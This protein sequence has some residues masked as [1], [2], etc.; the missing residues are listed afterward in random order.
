MIDFKADSFQI[1]D[2]DTLEPIA[3]YN[4]IGN[5]T[6]E[7]EVDTSS[8]TKEKLSFNHEAS[9]ECELTDCS[10]LLNYVTDLN[11]KPYYVEYYIPI[12]VQARWHKKPRINKKWLKRYGMKKDK[13][14]VRADVDSFGQDN[15]RDP[16]SLIKS[17]AVECSMALSNM[18]FEFRPDQLRRNLKIEKYV[19]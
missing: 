5:V 19:L 4:G 17:E 3:D 11:D 2:T 8:L 13:I 12:L 14:L 15:S 16:Y 7:S 6:I 18:R 9:F 1:L 10:S